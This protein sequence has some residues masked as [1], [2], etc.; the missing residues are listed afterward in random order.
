MTK[1]APHRIAIAGASGRMGQMLIEA[2]SAST[3]CLLTGALDVAASPAVGL[4]AAAFA[5]RSSGVLISSD[6]RQGLK[7]SRV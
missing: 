2:V 5:G 7:D 6:I 4:D 1:P 3:D